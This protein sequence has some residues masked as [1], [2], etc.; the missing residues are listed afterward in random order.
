MRP[1]NVVEAAKDAVCCVPASLRH[2][3]SA[4]R[5][6][7][8]CVC[9]LGAGIKEKTVVVLQLAGTSQWF[10]V[11]YHVLAPRPGNSSASSRYTPELCYRI[12]VEHLSRQLGE[13][14]C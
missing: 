1:L 8:G 3:R 10:E 2:S 11:K 9:T 7:G 4:G 12:R 6:C 5:G 13:R 14:S